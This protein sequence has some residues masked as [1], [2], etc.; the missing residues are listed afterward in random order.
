MPKLQTLD[1][2]P[3]YLSSDYKF[4]LIEFS[5]KLI[6]GSF[7]VCSNCHK[8]FHYLCNKPTVIS[9]YT[10]RILKILNV[11]FVNQPKNRYLII[12]Q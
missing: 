7:I 9:Y 1:L 4:M 3:I 11:I 10:K 2:H 6:I 12:N 5:T 8:K